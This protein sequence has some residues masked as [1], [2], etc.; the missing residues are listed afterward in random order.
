VG[1]LGVITCPVMV[2]IVGAPI[3]FSVNNPDYF[4]SIFDGFQGMGP[5]VAGMFCVIVSML[6]TKNE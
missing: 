1:I 4:S 3:R 5:F 6:E 2:E